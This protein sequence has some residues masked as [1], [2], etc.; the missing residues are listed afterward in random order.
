MIHTLTVGWDGTSMVLKPNQDTANI[1]GEVK[2]KELFLRP[3]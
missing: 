2:D 1:V 3:A